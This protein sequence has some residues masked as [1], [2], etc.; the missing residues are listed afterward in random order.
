LNFS[1]EG[2]FKNLRW[3]NM[4]MDEENKEES[5]LDQFNYI[6]EGLICF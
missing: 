2:I 4:M 1:V 6:L 5:D 3:I